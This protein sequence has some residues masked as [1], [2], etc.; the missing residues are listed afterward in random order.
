[1]TE[2]TLDVRLIPLEDLMESPLNPRRTFDQAALDELTE[3]VRAKG[4]L[5]PILVRPCPGGV[6]EVVCGARRLRASIAAGLGEIPA[7]VRDLDDAG[8]LEAM[9]VENSQRSD[10]HPIEESE[11]YVRLREL[12]PHLSV[13]DIA[14][15]VGKSAAVVYQR[16]QLRHLVP[17][18]REACLAGDVSPSVALLVARIEDPEAQEAGLKAVLPQYEGAGP[19]SVSD[20]RRILLRY[21]VTPLAEAPFALDDPNLAGAPSC[22]AC[23]KRSGNSPALFGDI[24]DGSSCTLR[25]C[26]ERK[27]AAYSLRA[28]EDARAAGRTIL[29]GDAAAAVFP[30]EW[31]DSPARGSHYVLLEESPDPM[32]YQGALSWRQ[33]LGDHAPEP[34]ALVVRPG[35]AP[36]EV[37]DGRELR[38]IAKKHKL[39]TTVPQ[40]PKGGIESDTG[41]EA[42]AEAER[43][44]ALGT[45]IQDETERR[46]V[47][48]GLE[49][50]EKH[51]AH[52]VLAQAIYTLNRFAIDLAFQRIK[53][54]GSG[55]KALTAF[56][57]DADADDLRRLLLRAALTDEAEAGDSDLAEWLGLDY[58]A[59]L[60]EVRAELTQPKAKAAAAKAKA[61]KATTKRAGKGR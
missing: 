45:Q 25:S 49:A 2:T 60:E 20:A 32:D 56:V 61:T 23:P 43:K 12:A 36:V 3:S 14:V 38:A 19:R 15:R 51:P 28:I 11:G 18:A 8:A 4:V 44:R 7:V 41:R 55:L 29:E 5:Q 46:Y 21:H 13:E 30:R 37:W 52:V 33:V 35:K 27:V 16:L 54:K 50:A 10:V 40:R 1:M 39:R 57:R 53:V 48:R 31:D 47:E 58:E 42:S 17:A 6:Y 9:V 26:Y 24:E 59:L 34:T 22:V